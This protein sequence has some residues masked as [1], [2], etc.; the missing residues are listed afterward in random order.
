[1]IAAAFQP[2]FLP[3]IG[4]F[5][6]IADA[7][8]FVVLD[9]VSFRKK[10]YI[11][12]NV[13]WVEDAPFRFTL[14]VHKVSQNRMIN[15]HTYINDGGLC[16]LLKKTYPAAHDFPQILDGIDRLNGESEESS[17]NKNVAEI[18][19]SLIQTVLDLLEINTK[20]IKASDLDISVEKG[21]KRIINIC[22]AVGAS[23]YINPIG[24]KELYDAQEFENAGLRLK[25]KDYH[26]QLTPRQLSSVVDSVFEWGVESTRRC[27]REMI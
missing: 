5:R 16:E 9:N 26:S 7:D 19:Q 2:Y 8:I 15:E 1:M 10:S 22:H 23:E 17:Q 18:N 27:M 13:I 20:V 12:R 14:P 4:Y 6:L 21:A 24:G 11:N 25:F 3:Y